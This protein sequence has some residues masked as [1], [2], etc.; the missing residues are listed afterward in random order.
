MSRVHVTQFSIEQGSPE[1]LRPVPASR[2]FKPVK[3]RGFTLAATDRPP[4]AGAWEHLLLTRNQLQRAL[5]GFLKRN[6]SRNNF[7]AAIET[8]G[9]D[10]PGSPRARR[11]VVARRSTEVVHRPSYWFNAHVVWAHVVEVDA[12]TLEYY[13]AHA[14]ED[15][16]RFAFDRLSTSASYSARLISTFKVPFS[17]CPR[18]DFIG[19]GPRPSSL[20]VHLHDRRG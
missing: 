3:Q 9:L 19:V 7:V 15:V 5:A 1:Q 18:E 16:A 13:A 8:V 4:G 17:D 2:A 11:V 14:D 10:I 12:Q 20:P 6:P